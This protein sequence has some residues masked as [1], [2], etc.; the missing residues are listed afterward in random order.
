MF[1][2]PSDIS[3]TGGMWKEWIQAVS[4]W[5][6]GP[7][8]FDTVLLKPNP[9]SKSTSNDKPTINLFSV[10][11]ACLFFSFEYDHASYEYALVHNY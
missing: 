8:W 2:I 3:G 10:A 4:S 7:P 11:Q 6:G 1:Y 5:R 9:E